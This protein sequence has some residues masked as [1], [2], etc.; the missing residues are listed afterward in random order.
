MDTA[1]RRVRLPCAPYGARREEASPAA[2]FR[3]DRPERPGN[4]VAD[5]IEDSCE[6]WYLDDLLIHDG[7]TPPIPEPSTWL[8]LS[9]GVL[10]VGAAARKRFFG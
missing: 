6:G 2:I 1:A 9:T 3:Q 10:G 7:E 8:L 4:P 5:A